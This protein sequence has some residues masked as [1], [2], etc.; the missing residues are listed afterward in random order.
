MKKTRGHISLFTAIVVVTV[1]LFFIFSARL[2]LRSGQRRLDAGR[3][4]ALWLARSAITAGVA[5]SRTVATEQGPA[6]I[7]VVRRGADLEATVELER[8]GTARV[9]TTAVGAGHAQWREAFE[10]AQR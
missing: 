6:V 10:R 9:Q 7:A 2:S 3:V 5:G 4:Q 1:G 8:V